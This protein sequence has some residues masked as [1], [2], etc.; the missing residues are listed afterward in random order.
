MLDKLDLD[1]KKLGERFY[2]ICLGIYI[3]VNFMSGTTFSKAYGLEATVFFLR[4]SQLTAILVLLKVFLFDKHRFKDLCLLGA[5]LGLLFIIC[6][7]AHELDP[8]FITCF[9]LAAFKVDY[10]EILKVYIGTEL[11]LLLGVYFATLIR[12]VPNNIIWR[13]GA[14][15]VRAGL[16]LATPS[17]L[18]AHIF[19]LMLAYAVYRDFSFKKQELAYLGVISALVFAIT[20]SRLDAILMVLLL[21]ALLFKQTLF[22]RLKA[23]GT[24]WVTGIVIGYAFFDLL[25]TYFYTPTSP[26]YQTLDLLLSR[27][28]FFGQMA[29]LN[30]PLRFLGQYIYQ[31][32]TGDP[33]GFEIYYFIDSAFVQALMMFG[34]IFFI[35]MLLL[36]S[37]LIKK[38]FKMSN[39]SLVVAILLIVFSMAINHHFW[40]ISYNI[41]ILATLA[42]LSAP[43]LEK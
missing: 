22:E 4:I 5:L 42:K 9:I 30:Y 16:G 17:D 37:Y 3:S 26:F 21:L 12:L 31:N 43:V 6:K 18:A 8:F 19:Y 38:S 7:Q 35:G 15:I 1:Q 32:G 40:H 23:L 24:A 28:L 25:L 27:R 14:G 41:I 39:Y 10:K 11:A 34:I 13:E 29:F 20:N 36:L 33:R 2:L